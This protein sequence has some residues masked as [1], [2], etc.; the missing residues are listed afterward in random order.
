MSMIF[1]SHY[2]YILA[3]EGRPVLTWPIIN[4]G[5]GRYDM[6]CFLGSKAKTFAKRRTAYKR[7]NSLCINNLTLVAH[8]YDTSNLLDPLFLSWFPGKTDGVV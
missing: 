4:S 1:H 7:D 8:E 2:S 3:G 6:L 5:Q